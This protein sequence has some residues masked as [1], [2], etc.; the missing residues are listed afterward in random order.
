MQMKEW[1]D[2]QVLLSEDKTPEELCKIRTEYSMEWYIR[3]AV[4]NKWLYYIF[5]FLG[6]LCPLVNVVLASCQVDTNMAIVILSAVTTLSASILAISNAR[7]K[8]ENYRSAAEFLKRE[9]TLFQARTGVYDGE[10]RVSAYL[11]T[12]EEFMDKVHAN[13]QKTFKED[14]EKKKKE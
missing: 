12:I 8:W 10:Q 5:T 13:W 14:K 9:Y 6:S 1:K 7:L 2:V 4:F 3:K 11:N